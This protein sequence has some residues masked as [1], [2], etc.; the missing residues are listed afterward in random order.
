MT[1]LNIRGYAAIF[2]TPDIDGCIIAPGAFKESLKE[3]E[4]KFPLLRN[5]NPDE[6]IGCI[7][8][9]KEDPIGLY[10]EGR[11]FPSYENSEEDLDEIKNGEMNGLAIGYLN[12]STRNSRTNE[13]GRLVTYDLFSIGVCYKPSHINTRITFVEEEK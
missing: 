5:F 6:P 8:L 12:D 2:N 9:I 10:I 1:K 11:L 3:K 4:G 13:E 7:D